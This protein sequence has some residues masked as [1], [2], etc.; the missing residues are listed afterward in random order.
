MANSLVPR[1]LEGHQGRLFSLC[2]MT[3]DQPRACLLY[4]PPFGEELNRCRHV[5]AEQARRFAAEGIACLILDL[6]GT[7]DSEGETADASWEIWHG[8]VLSAS[9]W[10]SEEL[11]TPVLLW[12]LRLGGLLALDVAAANPGLYA[13]ILLW[14]PVTNGQTYI[15]QLLRQRVAALASGSAEAE[16]TSQL[17]QRLAA[18][19]SLDVGGYT[20]GSRLT[21][22]VDAL[23]LSQIEGLRGSR[24]AW[25]EQSQTGAPSPAATK[26]AQQLI[27]QDNAVTLA[28]FSSPPIWQLVSRADMSDLYQKTLE[29]DLS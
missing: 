13:G 8:D 10:I 15:T 19:E 3:V 7:G 17:R 27:E 24:I 12:G 20:L 1:F 28:T 4:V 21:A 9:R 22:D 5:V 6:Y 16:T 26:G 18:G 23:K 14:Q 11:K 25:L 29:L 2:H